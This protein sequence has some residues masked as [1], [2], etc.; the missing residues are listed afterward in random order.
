MSNT[1]N[2]KPLLFLPGGATNV[3]SQL[4]ELE[5]ARG[6]AQVARDTLC[7]IFAAAKFDPDKESFDEVVGRIVR[8]LDP[9]APTKKEP[10][11]NPEN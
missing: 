6:I 10:E 9:E 1:K 2:G 4:Q 11:T 8:T 7:L 3:D 5:E